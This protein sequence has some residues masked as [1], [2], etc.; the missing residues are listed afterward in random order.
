MEKPS[1]FEEN[2]YVSK[3]DHFV[4]FEIIINFFFSKIY[5]SFFSKLIFFFQNW[6]FFNFF[7]KFKFF[8]FSFKIQ[9][10]VFQNSIFFFKIQN[11][12]F[13]NSNFSICFSK[14]DSKKMFFFNLIILFKILYL[15]KVIFE[16]SNQ[17]FAYRSKNPSCSEWRE[18][19]KTP[20]PLSRTSRTF[21]RSNFSLWSNMNET[22]SEI[23]KIEPEVTA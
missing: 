19:N 6:I 15:K 16:I 9:I 10:Y 3:N 18:T 1:N 11:F 8:N 4:Y 14:L 5:S 17:K 20:L 22:G 21:A 23:A 7:S 12:F 2:L 13:Q